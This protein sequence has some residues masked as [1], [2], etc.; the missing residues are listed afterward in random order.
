MSHKK[1]DFSLWQQCESKGQISLLAARVASHF[2]KDR[3]GERIIEDS[4][5]VSLSDCKYSKESLDN[6]TIECVADFTYLKSD[7]LNPMVKWGFRLEN[8]SFSCP[9]LNQHIGASGNMPGVLEGEGVGAE[10]YYT[11]DTKTGD[12]VL[13]EKPMVFT[14]LSGDET[15]KSIEVGVS[16]L[17]EKYTEMVIQ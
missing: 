7:F 12:Y 16:D 14:W 13:V 2:R 11:F 15:I 5:Y 10:L 1:R 9:Q 17:K 6:F 3:N 4:L 8:Q